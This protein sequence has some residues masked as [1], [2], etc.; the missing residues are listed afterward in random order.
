MRKVFLLAI[1]LAFG[2]AAQDY[3]SRPLRMVVGFP[4]GG[5]T[6]VVAHS[7]AGQLVTI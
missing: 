1:A 6:D 2:A 3:P 4:P 7:H 5:G